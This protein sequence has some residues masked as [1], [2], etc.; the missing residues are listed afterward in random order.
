[1]SVSHECD[2][3]IVTYSDVNPYNGMDRA[4]N[5]IYAGWSAE[6]PVRPH[7]LLRPTLFLGMLDENGLYLKKNNVDE[8]F[9]PVYMRPPSYTIYSLIQGEV[10]LYDRVKLYASCQ[11]DYSVTHGM[12]SRIRF[13]TEIEAHYRNLSGGIEW[14]H[15]LRLHGKGWAFSE[16]RLYI[17]FKGKSSLL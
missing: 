3:D 11:P 10:N 9:D 16:L 8:N 2:H 12:W 15:E 17:S 1:M 5:N 7:F 4:Y 13:G 6:F 14:K